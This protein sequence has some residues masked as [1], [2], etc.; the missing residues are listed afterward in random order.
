MGTLALCYVGR[1]GRKTRADTVAAPCAKR[2]SE[3]ILLIGC[4]KER[5]LDERQYSRLFRKPLI[6]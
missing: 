4:G 5:E 2:A 3:R 6:R 1:T